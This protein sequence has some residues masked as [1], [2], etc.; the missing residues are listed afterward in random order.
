MRNV[1]LGVVGLFLGIGVMIGV[2]R[3][4]LEGGHS[5]ISEDSGLALRVL[6]FSLGAF[7][8]GEGVYLFKRPK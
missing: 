6:A 7:V 3:A 1:A 8:F 5:S 4:A 2:P